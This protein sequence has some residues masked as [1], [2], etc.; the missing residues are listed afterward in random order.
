MKKTKFSRRDFLGLSATTAAGVILTACAPAV[1]PAAED[2]MEEQAAEPAGDTAAA[3]DGG[4][5]TF[6]TGSPWGDVQPVPAD[7]SV[8]LQQQHAGHADPQPAV[9]S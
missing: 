2:A 8:R 3:D 4:T 6:N 1:P 5:L 9:R 7:L